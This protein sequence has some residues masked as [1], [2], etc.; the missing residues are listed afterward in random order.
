M[1]LSNLHKIAVRGEVKSS[2]KPGNFS[3][4]VN[5][6]SHFFKQHFPVFVDAVP[7]SH[8]VATLKRVFQL[9][10]PGSLDEFKTEMS[11]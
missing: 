3:V 11:T 2:T 7:L 4:L 6:I 8:A 9:I 1:T 10:I 5:C